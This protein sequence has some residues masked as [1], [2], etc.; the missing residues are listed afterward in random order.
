MNNISG[1]GRS[2]PLSPLGKQHSDS[3][4]AEAVTSS[5][6]RGSDNA[7]FSLNAKYLSKVMNLPVRENLVNDIRSQISAGTY[8]TPEKIDAL[9]GNLA[10]DL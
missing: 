7:E 10:E 1:I 5:S 9:L 6:S 8:E 4:R 2:I 3:K